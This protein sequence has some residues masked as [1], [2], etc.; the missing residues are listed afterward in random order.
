MFKSC[1]HL[2]AYEFLS[3]LYSDSFQAYERMYQLRN[4]VEVHGNTDYAVIVW[5]DKDN[6]YDCDDYSVIAQIGRWIAE[7]LPGIDYIYVDFKD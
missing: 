7:H 6:Y 3:M 2:D 4:E 1:L 5:S